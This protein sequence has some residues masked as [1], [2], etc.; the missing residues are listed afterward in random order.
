MRSLYANVA[1]PRDLAAA[2]GVPQGVSDAWRHLVAFYRDMMNAQEMREAILAA[3]AE[4]Y[5]DSMRQA[6]M[7]AVMKDAQPGEQGAV[8]QF[9]A[10]LEDFYEERYGCGKEVRAPAEQARFTNAQL[11]ALR[12][13]R[14]PS[15]RLQDY[16]EAPEA[17]AD[18]A[19]ARAIKV[20]G[21]LYLE[22]DDDWTGIGWPDPDMPPAALLLQLGL[23]GRWRM[24]GKLARDRA[25]V[26]YSVLFTLDMGNRLLERAALE[27]R[28]YEEMFCDTDMHTERRVLHTAM[29]LTPL[30]H[31]PPE[32][33]D[34]F[35]VH[36]LKD[37]AGDNGIPPLFY[38]ALAYY[39]RTCTMDGRL[40]IE[41][42]V[43]STAAR[44]GSAAQLLTSI[45]YDARENMP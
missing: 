31:C 8:Q 29:V 5:N 23:D 20:H 11:R 34:F 16:V 6:V 9:V 45:R 41:D 44:D 40:D 36:Y 17:P 39:L 35:I 38:D 32:R 7:Q 27:L 2:E 43:F 25:S 1:R 14:D 3:P 10:A 19:L 37:L 24:L 42:T 33:T 13:G 12:E 21:E 18:D 22:P 4:T 30:G 15:L 28:R 26:L